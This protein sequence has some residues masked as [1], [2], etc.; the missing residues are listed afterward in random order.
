MQ[1][2]EYLKSR[3]APYGYI[4]VV[5]KND[6]KKYRVHG[7]IR[8]STTVATFRSTDYT[9]S[10]KNRTP[11][12]TE[13]FVEGTKKVGSARINEYLTFD[14]T[15]VQVLD[16]DDQSAFETAYPDISKQIDS[17]PHYLSRNKRLKHVFIEI[18]WT[19]CRKR[20]RIEGTNQSCDWC[21]GQ[22]MWVRTDEMMVNAGAQPLKVSGKLFAPIRAKKK[23]ST[24]S[25]KATIVKANASTGVKN[26]EKKKPS[27]QSDATVLK[28]EPEYIDNSV[29][30]KC[31]PTAEEMANGL[32]MISM[33]YIDSYESWMKIGTIL[34]KCYDRVSA[35]KLFEQFSRK[36]VKFPGR[37]E[38]SHAFDNFNVSADLH[39]ATICYYIK[40]SVGPIEFHKWRGAFLSV[41]DM[42]AGDRVLADYFYTAMGCTHFRITDKNGGGYVYDDN[43]RLWVKTCAQNIANK[44]GR[45]VAQQMKLCVWRYKQ[46]CQEKDIELSKERL[47]FLQGCIVAMNSS[48]K[49]VQLSKLVWDTPCYDPDFRTNINSSPSELPIADGFVLCL[50]TGATRLRTPA[51]LWS[52]ELDVSTR[53]PENKAAQEKAFRFFQSVC[54]DDNDI[55]TYLLE[56][57][58]FSMTGRTDARTLWILYGSGRNGKS[59]CMNLMQLILKDMYAVLS[60]SALID[61]NKSG[62]GATP[63]LMCLQTARCGVVSEIKEGSRLDAKRVKWLTGNEAITCRALYQDPITFIPKTK[64]LLLSNHL[65]GFDSLDTAMTDRVRVIPFLARFEATKENGQFVRSL[66]HIDV[67]NEI[68]RLLV[69]SC[70]A[71]YERGELLPQPKIAQQATQSCNK[72]Q[73]TVGMWLQ[74]ETEECDTGVYFR[75]DAF[76]C[77]EEWVADSE[78]VA[79]TKKKFFKACAKK[80]LSIKKKSDLNTGKRSWA[81]VGIRRKESS[82]SK[83]QGEEE[84]FSDDEPEISNSTTE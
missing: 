48:Q 52:F 75:H 51:D 53:V 81:F 42:A 21:A 35:Y 80:G 56:V 59:T 34:K 8:W 72:E 19:G 15:N 49:S 32:G 24:K 40:E 31:V 1:V 28:P 60:E 74:E 22:S 7:G 77:Y 2:C 55:C 4:R 10:V 38:V 78:H 5:E 36:S 23:S 37:A 70:I 39:F 61:Q 12:F 3:D 45:F 65:P 64:C 43:K 6:G 54:K 41:H 79:L 9:E 20:K 83:E 82:A 68:F 63:E 71:Y 73:D 14:S 57:L 66:E 84:L 62:G 11:V 58:G 18:D 69:H 33:K 16:I 13:P 44:V 26:K 76:N 27:M 29:R 50:K 67:L 46:E 47:R 30:G 17:A 25:K